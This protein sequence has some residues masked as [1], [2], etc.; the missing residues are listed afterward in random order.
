MKYEDKILCIEK[1]ISEVLLS[2]NQKSLFENYN[3]QID[4]GLHFK[5]WVRVYLVKQNTISLTFE[6][7]YG[8]LRIDIDKAEEIFS[9]DFD[10][11]C[12]NSSELKKTLKMIFTS[13]IMVQYCGKNITILYF[14]KNNHCLKYNYYNTLI[15]YFCSLHKCVEEVFSPIFS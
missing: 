1:I 13:T 12:N 6:I 4:E 15:P 9:F 7:S 14:I 8:G 10:E 3:F 11:I 5:N 2:L